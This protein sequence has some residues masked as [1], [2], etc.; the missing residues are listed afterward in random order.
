MSR[1]FGSAAN[2]GLVDSSTSLLEETL[3]QL[4][5]AGPKGPPLTGRRTY[6]AIVEQLPLVEL[7]VRESVDAGS[8]FVIWGAY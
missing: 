3:R 8:L 7:G 6:V 4:T 1:G 2:L 5:D